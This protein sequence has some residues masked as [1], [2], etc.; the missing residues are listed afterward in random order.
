MATTRHPG[1]V[2][3]F[4]NSFG[5]RQLRVLARPINGES[6]SDMCFPPGLRVH[7]TGVASITMDTE[8]RRSLSVAQHVSKMR[9]CPFEN[10]QG[11]GWRAVLRVS[12]SEQTLMSTL[13]QQPVPLFSMTQVGS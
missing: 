1:S 13:A 6:V 9:E 10:G 11:S 7:G 12:D 3:A 8:S 4:H 5:Q 2:H